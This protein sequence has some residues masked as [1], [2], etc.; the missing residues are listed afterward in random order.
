M[1]GVAHVI[2][3]TSDHFGKLY[4]KASALG[5]LEGYL[6]K[7]MVYNGPSGGCRACRTRR[8]KVN[9]PMPH[10]FAI[11]ISQC[12][13]SRPACSNCIRRKQPCPG[14]ADV[15]DGA[16]RSQNDIVIRR[17]E[18]QK[19]TGKDDKGKTPSR[20]SSPGSETST[21]LI[22]TSSTTTV[23]SSS[24]GPLQWIVYSAGVAPSNAPSPALSPSHDEDVVEDSPQSVEIPAEFD[25]LVGSVPG[26]LREDPQMAAVG[27]FFRH[28]GLSMFNPDSHAGF[29]SAWQPMF[30]RSAPDSPL[31]N[32]TAAVAVNIAMMWCF[33]GCDTRLPRGL[34]T[35]AIA[36][37]RKAM[38]SP[39]ESKTDE[40][41]MTILIFDLY[42][43]LLLHYTP[44]IPNYGKHKD[45]A[46]ALIEHRS[47]A[48]YLTTSSKSMIDGTR[49][50]LLHYILAQRKRFPDELVEMFQQGSKPSPA[51][52]LD[53]ISMQVTALQAEVFSL[54]REDPES[55]I[56][57]E[58]RLRYE[59]IIENAIRVETLL[60]EW[61]FK[62]LTPAWKPYY[63]SRASVTPSISAAGFYGPHCVVW[64][65]LAFGD[66]WATHAT[67]CMYTLQVIRQA[68]SD[69]PS[70]LLERKYQTLL[71][72]T[73]LQMQEFV[74]F[75]CFS[76]PFHIGDTMVPTNPLNAESIS[77]PYTIT[78][79]EKTGLNKRIPDPL[80]DY[81]VRT[82]ASGGWI[83]YS[84][85]VTLYRFAEPEDDAVPI[86]L[87]DGQLDWIKDQVKRLQRIFLF[88][89]PPW[90]KRLSPPY[91][92]LKSNA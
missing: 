2:G 38:L 30:L 83:I 42:D 68:I 54:R 72:Q 65:E 56:A 28:Y 21:E 49:H 86:V 67:R 16:H 41:L 18:K 33:K 61:K 4:T 91:H 78:R 43:T 23:S 64:Q 27:F 17:V 57:S 88:V 35:K 52:S 32:A 46:L 34:F 66:L 25:H 73:D 51:G 3:A 39:T 20:S 31:R 84:H 44:G 36:A 58:R 59:E 90:F 79:D 77:F 40:L 37:T 71:N 55:L 80:T 70:L 87:R 11:N 85:L 6:K 89:D 22:P 45:G 14:Y 15:F 24:R 74:D 10:R 50:S 76:V 92:V 48:N 1:D 13:Q 26:G 75:V 81:Q 7:I 12:D 82:A 19:N 8:V 9:L 53:L 60:V 5:T 29:H 69:E 47:D 63:I 62:T